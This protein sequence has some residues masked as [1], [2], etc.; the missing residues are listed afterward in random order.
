MCVCVCVCVCVYMHACVHM[1][2]HVRVFLVFLGCRE[3]FLRVYVRACIVCA[4]V[5]VFG[6][7]EKGT[8]LLQRCLFVGHVFAGSEY[9]ACCY[10]VLF[11]IHAWYMQA[12]ICQLVAVCHT[13]TALCLVIERPF[14][15]CAR[16][17]HERVALH[18]GT[19]AD[20]ISYLAQFF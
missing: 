18:L 15:G 2:A 11:R 5:F 17:W 14:G 10:P 6:I 1:H 8:D 3:F 20:R 9:T 16:R 19:H 7:K 12:V 13:R 4:C